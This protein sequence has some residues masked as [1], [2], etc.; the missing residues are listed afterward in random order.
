MKKKKANDL[1]S[2]IV[3]CYNGSKYIN[4]CL[5]SIINQTYQNIEIIVVDDGSK[6]NS[7]SLINK[8]AKENNKIKYFYKSNG[9]LSS[10]R[11]YG[12]TKATGKFITF[13]DIDDYIDKE[14]I[15]KLYNSIIENNS[16]ISI[17]EIKRIYKDHESI[18]HINSN[19]ID[20]C[21]YPA[22]W[23]KMYKIELFDNISFPEEKWYEDLGT[24][25]KL[26]MLYK[27][28]IVNEPLYNYIQNSSSIMH[29]FDNRIFDIY[30][31]IDELEKYLKNNNKYKDNID[32]IEFINIYHLLIGTVYRL[33]FMNNFK[34]N[35]IKK[36]HL[37]I[38]KK[39]PN[40]RKNKFIKLN[41]NYIYK[42]YLTC[43]N[44]HFYILIY[45]L[46][47]LFNKKADL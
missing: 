40:W 25:P 17:C 13:I 22:A 11:N 9:G 10:A 31:I 41:L 45:V 18:N 23:N 14:Y 27:Y 21:M 46:L 3:A 47:K 28:S 29:T 7:K 32:K 42:V 4:K 26:T 44:L 2:I 37:Y 39:Y 34:I 30:D 12:I 36:I 38:K 5:E 1:I 16:D 35:D 15:F 6:D 8:Y 20:S 24:T 19:I 43:M 33:S